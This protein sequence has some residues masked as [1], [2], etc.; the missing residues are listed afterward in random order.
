VWALRPAFHTGYPFLTVPKQ[1]ICHKIVEP[2]LF[3]GT[4]ISD[5]YQSVIVQC[6]SLLELHKIILYYSISELS[7]C[8]SF[9]KSKFLLLTITFLRRRD[10]DLKKLLNILIIQRR[11]ELDCRTA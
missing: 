4:V 9:F 3:E 1:K 7:G 11:L 5:A 10:F 2:L 8:S 6:C